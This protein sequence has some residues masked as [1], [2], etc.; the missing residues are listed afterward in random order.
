MFVNMLLEFHDCVQRIWKAGRN[1]RKNTFM[2]ELNMDCDLAYRTIGRDLH[3]SASRKFH[4][5]VTLFLFFTLYKY[6]F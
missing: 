3:V 6:N 4:F 2:F 5:N 1:S